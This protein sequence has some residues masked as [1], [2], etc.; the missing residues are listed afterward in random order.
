LTG[1]DDLESGA[2]ISGYTA[3]VSGP[4]K[5]NLSLA[6]PHRQWVAIAQHEDEHR[7][8]NAAGFGALSGGVPMYLIPR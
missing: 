4:S 3:N 5:E 2:D 7:A 1:L 6:L 8:D